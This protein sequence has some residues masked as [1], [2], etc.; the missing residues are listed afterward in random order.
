MKREYATATA[1]PASSGTT[2]P[3]ITA[4]PPASGMGLEWILRWPGSSIV[5]LRRHQR[6]QTGSETAVA[7]AAEST[8]RGINDK[9]VHRFRQ[10]P[11]FR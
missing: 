5:P 7:S 8:G 10:Q 3:V 11:S 4:R 2:R 1:A 9:D 6:R